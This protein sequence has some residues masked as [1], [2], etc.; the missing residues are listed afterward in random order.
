M[1]VVGNSGGADLI[2]A[3]TAS[4]CLVVSKVKTNG[5]DRENDVDRKLMFETEIHLYVGDLFV[6]G[7]EGGVCWAVRASRLCCVDIENL[8]IK[9]TLV[10]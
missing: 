1:M 9:N 8:E 5:G 3:T 4:D 7:L 10:N 2:L 6:S